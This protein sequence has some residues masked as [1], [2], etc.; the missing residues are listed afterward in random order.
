MFVYNVEQNGKKVKLSVPK[1]GELKSADLRKIRKL[2]LEDQLFTL[3]E[4]ILSEDELSIVDAMTMYELN[5]FFQ[6][7]QKDSEVTAGE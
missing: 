6:A 2:D 4:N 5:E 3:L 1:F 7:W